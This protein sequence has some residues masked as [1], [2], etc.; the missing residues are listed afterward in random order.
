MTTADLTSVMSAEASR[1]RIYDLTHAGICSLWTGQHLTP[2]SQT[3]PSLPYR[4]QSALTRRDIDPEYL[5]VVNEI[6]GM[7][8]QTGQWAKP[9]SSKLPYGQRDGIRR[10]IL[11]IC[12]EELEGEIDRFVISLPF[13]AR[14]P[15][16]SRYPKHLLR[17]YAS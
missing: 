17:T 6:N 14:C 4:S 15:S 1:A 16:F 11:G 7:R 9:G 3:S 13:V 12:G 8:M 10:M 5:A 2:P